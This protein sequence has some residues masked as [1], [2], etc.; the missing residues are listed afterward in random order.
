MLQERW[1]MCCCNISLLPNHAKHWYKKL[2]LFGWIDSPSFEVQFNF[3]SKTKNYFCRKMETVSETAFRAMS[4]K[5]VPTTR[6]LTP[7]P[8]KAL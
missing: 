7:V 5:A 8:M 1:K 3:S 2:H 6:I 4:S